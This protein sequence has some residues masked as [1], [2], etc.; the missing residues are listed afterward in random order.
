MKEVIK[1]LLIDDDEDDYIITEDIIEEI[2]VQKYELD[3]IPSYEEAIAVI[4]KGEHDIYIVDFRLGA[5]N[6]LDVISEAQANGID[7]PFILL[8]G[9]GDL[10]TD[11]K[12][13]AVGAYD[14]LVKGSINAA[15]L[16]KS[17]RHSIQHNH[18]LRKIRLLNE[19]LEERVQERTKQLD[20]AILELQKTNLDLQ[21]QI[22]E[23]Q[24]AR[25]ALKES[26]KIYR[27]IA[28]NFP[29]GII[30]VLDKELNCVFADGKGLYSLGYMPDDM[31][32]NPFFVFNYKDADKEYGSAEYV[33]RIH[34]ELLR[35]FDGVE[36]ILEV[37][38]QKKQFALNVVPLFNSHG[39]SHQLL[40]VAMD[41]TEQKKAD[42]E[43]RKALAKEKQLSELKSRFVSMASHEFRTPLSTILSSVSLISRYTGEEHQEKREKHIKRIKSSV[44]NLTQ[45]L[46]DFL[47][48][49]RLEEGKSLVH[50]NFI[51]V[52]PYIKEI[53]EEMKAVKKPNQR[54]IYKH[55]GGELTIYSD[56]QL[57]KNILIN[58]VSNA[59]KY[60]GNGE[61]IW[62]TSFQEGNN[63]KVSVKDEG[64][65]IPDEDQQHLFGRFFRSENAM[66]IQGTGLGLHIVKRY[67]DLIK[68]KITYE[69][70]LD[71]GTTFTV[72][73]PVD[74][75]SKIKRHEKNPIN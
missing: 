30:C 69:S 49:S 59:I 23:K 13:M 29:N 61:N 75:T 60:S 20:L 55:E 72:S 66:N 43:I 65:G 41:I 54:L 22:K 39:E 48:L 14:Y 32:G 19:K 12:A 46:N 44:Q 71:Y 28:H 26:Q 35:S 25:D 10:A 18:N 24:S 37:E 5:M 2:T 9:Q 45:I 34:K 47:S 1:I 53:T 67:I 17:I 64:I 70:K 16:E 36:N 63:L 38:F 42:N 33:E 6:G 57:M 52:E 7:K 74:I 50:N 51:D 31:V 8:T 68:G 4:K 11:E 15:Q 62:I 40:V 56:R 73:I 21:R 58:L 27:T 3:W